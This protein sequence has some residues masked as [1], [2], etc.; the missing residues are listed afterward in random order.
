M[1][2]LTL[3]MLKRYVF[4]RH[5]AYADEV[6]KGPGIGEDAAVI[7]LTK[8]LYMITHTDPITAAKKNLGRLAIYISSNDIAVKGVRPKYA[9]ITLL[10]K[11]SSTEDEINSITAQLDE[12]AKNLDISIVGGHTE[13]VENLDMNIAVVTQIGFS[14]K[15]PSS[16]SEIRP[17]DVLI[18]VN[19][20]AIEGTAVIANDYPELILQFDEGALEL[21]MSYIDRITI[22]NDALKLNSLGI[23]VMHDPTEG[24]II[25]GAVEMALASKLKLKVEEEKVLTT[26]L[27]RS[28]CDHL[29]LDPLKLLSSG[30][31][32]AAT[33]PKKAELVLEVLKEKASIIGEFVKGEPSLHINRTTGIE[34]YREPPQD[35]IY[36]LTKKTGPSF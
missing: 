26:P 2:K 36:K 19:E 18:Q 29:N 33:K 6:L 21:A 25:G 32:L 11:K 20:A 3:D 27:S 35:E 16:I 28:I 31:I 5:G 23:K 12:T 30:A 24:G 34:V 10:L 9:L 1:A 15:K 17:G 8:K 14:S 4:S 13:I 22:I 7:R